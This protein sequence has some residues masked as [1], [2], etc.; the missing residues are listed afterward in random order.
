MFDRKF[1][2]IIKR[3]HLKLIVMSFDNY[4]IAVYFY[5]VKNTVHFNGTKNIIAVDDLGEDENDEFAEAVQ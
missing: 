4:V 3:H 2:V 1:N 5:N